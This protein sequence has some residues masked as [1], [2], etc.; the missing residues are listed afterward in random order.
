M[1]FGEDIGGKSGAERLCPASLGF[2][3]RQCVHFLRSGKTGNGRVIRFSRQRFFILCV[4][5]PDGFFMLKFLQFK[6]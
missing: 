2:H 4:L 1:D 3:I 6:R 5:S